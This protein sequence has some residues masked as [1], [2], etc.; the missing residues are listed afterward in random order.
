MSASWQY[1]EDVV[2]ASVV[3]KPVSV[4]KPVGFFRRLLRYDPQQVAPGPADVSS[5]PPEK[6]DLEVAK[7]ALEQAN[8][9]IEAQL[10]IKTSTEARAIALAGSCITV[11]T[12]VVGA[13]LVELTSQQRITLLAAAG[14]AAVCLS[15]AVYCAYRSIDPREITLPGRLP[16]DLWD[17]LIDVELSKGQFTAI[18][19]AGLQRAM[20]ENEI[21]QRERATWLQ[22]SLSVAVAAVPFS[23]VFAIGVA[24][25]TYIVG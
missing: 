3:P 4:P 11:L 10:A 18:L 23:F 7:T 12:A 14:M 5:P 16:S 1:P 2:Q 19:V 25:L 13:G 15:I 24:A 9:R 20:V 17:D 21:L 6:I 8:K 22:R